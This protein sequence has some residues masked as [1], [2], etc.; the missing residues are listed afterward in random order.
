MLAIDWTGSMGS[1]LSS[2]DEMRTPKRLKISP[3]FP[4][5]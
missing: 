4:T 3:L 5:L 1:A 2:P